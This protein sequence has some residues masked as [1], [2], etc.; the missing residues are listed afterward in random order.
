MQN[1]PQAHDAA[2]QPDAGPVRVSG[3]ATPGAPWEKPVLSVHGDVRQLTMGVST[4]PGESGNEGS[5][6]P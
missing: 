2:V 5:R 6:R 4:P 1:R 3:P